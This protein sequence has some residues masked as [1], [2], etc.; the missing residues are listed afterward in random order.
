MTA[1]SHCGREAAPNN[2]Y[3]Q[4]CG[5]RLDAQPVDGQPA[6]VAAGASEAGAASQN[7]DD[8]YFASPPWMQVVG[9]GGEAAA[10]APVH[11]APVATA[12]A[13]GRLIVRS[14]SSGEGQIGADEREYI[15]D[16]NDIAIGR[17]PSCDIA[18]SGDQL[19]S[20][21]HAL[22]RFKGGRYTVV[23]LGSSNGTYVNDREI[24]EETALED[25]D[26]I[27]VGGHEILFST[28]PASPHAS[29]AGIRL[30]A[31]LPLAPLAET[32]PSVP[33][34]DLSGQ[35]PAAP[36]NDVI[37][38]EAGEAPASAEA[39]HAVEAEEAIEPLESVAAE[40]A[41]V[42]PPSQ[43]AESAD[44]A[45]DAGADAAPAEDA[46]EDVADADS[47]AP[48]TEGAVNFILSDGGDAPASGAS[49]ADLDTL[50]TQLTEA[51]AALTER[52][53]QNAAHAA[54]LKAA[55]GGVRSQLASAL[56]AS[57]PTPDDTST[58]D[59]SE[60]VFV[61]RQAAENPRHLD[62][63]TTLAARAGE[64]AEAL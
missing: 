63:V 23:D 12:V 53:T 29:L 19:A 8:G 64:I 55:L 39:P 57:A 32:N 20:R 16:E 46:F 35:A 10:S 28:G 41:I 51:S 3:C 54:R 2:L 30:S 25:G 4:F 22:L 6:A 13:R 9:E 47:V 24:R 42:T 1:C 60:L 49:D 21:R 43:G 62:Y 33:A 45:A 50:R 52:A 7:G 36:P 44:D 56:A 17:S 34:I 18:L 14:A 27:K 11:A 48:E 15:L 31:P 59:L 37:A 61:A 5:Q 40:E 38:S 58:G 26:Y